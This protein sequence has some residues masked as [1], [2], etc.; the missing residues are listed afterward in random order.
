MQIHVQSAKYN[1]GMH[2]P[3][4]RDESFCK[5]Y[6][7]VHRACVLNETLLVGAN[8]VEVINWVVDS[9]FEATAVVNDRF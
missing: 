9:E 6:F 7:S 4:F 5:Y 2:Y 3:Y 1:H 8:D